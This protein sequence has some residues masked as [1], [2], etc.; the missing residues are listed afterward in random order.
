MPSPFDGRWSLAAVDGAVAFY[1][2]INS[3]EDH[4]TMLRKLAE[5][6]KKDSS[7]YVEEL[8]VEG[9]TFHRQAYVNGEKKKDSGPAPLNT[10]VS[11]KI[12]DGRPAK[13]KIVKESESK[14]VRTEV[15]DGFKITSTFEVKG[16]ELTLTM[17]SGSVTT[18]EK[19]K[20]VG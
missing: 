14:L 6:V 3:P 8:K 4:K 13:I 10:E 2:S 17:S 19:Y 18:S 20:R 11:A 16:D 7:V 12:A 1:D 15:G 9:D 5:A